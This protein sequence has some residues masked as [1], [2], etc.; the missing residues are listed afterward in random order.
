[1]NFVLNFPVIGENVLTFQTV[2]WFPSVLQIRVV[3]L[4]PVVHRG[5]VF[6][7]VS[8][9]LLLMPINFELRAHRDDF[10]LLT[11]KS[12][13]HYFVLFQV[14]D[15]PDLHHLL[16]KVIVRAIE[17]A[18]VKSKVRLQ[19]AVNCEHGRAHCS[20]PLIVDHCD[21]RCSEGVAFQRFAREEES[22][23]HHIVGEEFTAVALP[24]IQL[25]LLVLKLR[26]GGCYVVICCVAIF[27][28]EVVMLI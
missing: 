12:F 1:M 10:K 26:V 28:A 24:P 20:E 19:T 22:I 6:L 11:A 16:L 8:F 18:I 3:K 13:F 15:V 4:K 14:E 5:R 7:F 21:K 27:F 17:Q 9:F 23:E 25:Q 2:E